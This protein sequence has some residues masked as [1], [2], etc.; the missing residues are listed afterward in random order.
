MYQLSARFPGPTTPRDFVTLLLT[1]NDPQGDDEGNSR[2]RRPRQFMVISKP[3]IHPD[4]PQ[5]QGFVRGQYESV[6]VVREIPVDKPLRRVRSSIDL[7]SDAFSRGDSGNP[8]KE[9]LLRSARQAASNS[10]NLQARPDN[11]M[12][13]FAAG[14]VKQSKSE[15]G[16][17]DEDEPE[18]AIEWL[19]ITRSDPGGSVPRFMVERGTPPG[20]V[21][22][23]G[24]LLDWLSRKQSDTARRE[25]IEA[26][27]AGG[28]DADEPDDAKTSPL[29]GETKMTTTNPGQTRAADEAPNAGPGG[30]YGMITSALEAAGSAVV[31]KMHDAPDSYQ[32][33]DDDDEDDT[34][35]SASFASAEEGEPSSSLAGPGSL[36]ADEVVSSSRSARS[37]VSGES[38]VPSAA[39]TSA[40]QRD[41]T[42]RKLEERHRKA[43]EKAAR[44][45]ERALAKRKEGEERDAQ[46]AARL[47]DKHEKELAKREEKYMREV[48]KLEEKRARAAEREGRAGLQAELE[49]TRAERDVALKQVE[50]LR[51]QVGELQTQ[52]TRLVARMGKMGGMAGAEAS[53]DDLRKAPGQ[54]TK[55]R[56]HQD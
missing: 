47:R 27:G 7:G 24:R 5:R 1:S 42:L 15:A 46:A 41:K 23:A 30:F 3:C 53:W 31:G 55:A 21:N 28:A 13:S 25:A 35:S 44:E 54:E 49:R 16:S 37:A 26:G 4:C 51:D 43:R 50:M 9:A 11:R 14:P 32:G 36:P 40:A 22:D 29:P 39:S 2:N 48:R 34:S 18:M 52:N 8:G 6:E 33:T 10:G 45:H 19:M 17:D 56:S 38:Q 20:I 12:V